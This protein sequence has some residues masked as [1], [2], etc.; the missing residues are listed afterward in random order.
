M[1]MLSLLPRIAQVA[2]AHAING[3]LEGVAVALFTCVFLWA[4]SCR[5]SRTRFAVLFS[6]L[7]AITGLSLLAV[8]PQTSAA[9]AASPRL[10]LPIAWAE[11]ALIAWA[12]CA[13]AGLFRIAI[14]LI[15]LHRLKSD[16][17]PIP[18][19]AI[20]DELR[21]TLEQFCSRRRR[22]DIRISG[23]L[24]VPAAVG[25]FRSAVVLP[26]WIVEELSPGELN[27]VVLHELSH[28][29]RWDDW[30]N[31]VQRVVRALLF[32]HPA[33]WWLDSRLTLER[34]MACD[35]LVLAHIG[36]AR[37]YA[38]C[39]VS[40]AEKSAINSRLALALAAVTRMKQTTARLARI[41]D[42]G[43]LVETR[44]SRS[45]VSAVAIVST[46]ALVALPHTP[47]LIAFQSGSGTSEHAE[48][49]SQKV[50]ARTWGDVIPANYKSADSPR[51]M[52]TSLRYS[53]N[54]NQALKSSEIRRTRAERVT[55]K[56]SHR[57][58]PIVTRAA[59]RDE[60]IAPAPTLLMVMQSEQYGNEYSTVLTIY[61]WQ[62][63]PSIKDQARRPATIQNGT[64]SK[65]I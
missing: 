40:V 55:S 59:F 52:Q 30:T 18:D 24:R 42:P 23:S 16:C 29:L 31:L 45:A 22:V 5:N 56:P 7:L 34:E 14:G 50:N 33:V 2:G 47:A 36:N 39:L 9:S 43:R 32:F 44:L 63:T 10:T 62:T 6:T 25:F 35:D 46:L 11:Y 3:V 38:E 48:L 1:T 12:V 61:V 64:V 37:G 28:L 65:A 49:N 8:A 19:S 57:K 58:S 26:R 54:A 17:R 60:S 51:I 15:K 41:L 20:N 27:A 13:A 4:I 53:E 21:Q